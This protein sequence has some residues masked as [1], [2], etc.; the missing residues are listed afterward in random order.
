MDAKINEW[1]VEGTSDGNDR[2][3][4]SSRHKNNLD[5]LNKDLD[6][7]MK[8]GAIESKVSSTRIVAALFNCITSS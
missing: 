4:Q 1:D 6:R 7:Q 3:D 8:L 5:R 2:R